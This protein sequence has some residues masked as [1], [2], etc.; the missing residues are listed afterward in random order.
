MLLWLGFLRFIVRRWL[1]REFIIS[2]YIWNVENY[3][4]ATAY[5]QE[6]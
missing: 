1:S 5:R 4:G 2:N 6:L 3:T